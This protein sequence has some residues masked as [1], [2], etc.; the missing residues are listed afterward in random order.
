MAQA[1]TLLPSQHFCRQ[2]RLLF[3]ELPCKLRSFAKFI[4][5]DFVHSNQLSLL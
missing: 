4:A 3:D 1:G 2:I 5:Y